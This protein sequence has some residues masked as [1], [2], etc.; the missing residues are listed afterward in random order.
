MGRINRRIYAT[1]RKR[2]SAFKMFAPAYTGPRREYS[3]DELATQ[4]SRQESDLRD[5]MSDDN[6][7]RPQ[8]GVAMGGP[9]PFERLRNPYEGV[10]SD[11]DMYRPQRGDEMIG[12]EGR[13]GPWA[14][15]LPPPYLKGRGKSGQEG[16]ES[17]TYTITK[18]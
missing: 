13:G 18:A 12:R 8:Q 5:A 11:R 7:Y 2:S 15:V 4:K 9:N 14:E 3:A 16:V 1:R 10:M 17:G 6:M